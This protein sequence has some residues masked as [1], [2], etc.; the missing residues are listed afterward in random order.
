MEIS[1]SQQQSKN[2]F[3]NNFQGPYSYS[4]KDFTRRGNSLK[5]VEKVLKHKGNH[6]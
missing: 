4:Q 6:E 3:N 5:E 1:Y 2:K